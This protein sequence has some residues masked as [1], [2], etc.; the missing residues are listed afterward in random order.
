MAAPGF[1]PGVT[2]VREGAAGVEAFAVAA[3]SA[4]GHA[5]GV[6]WAVVEAPGPAYLVLSE[7][8]ARGWTASV[9]GAPAAVEAADGTL[10]GLPV[11]AGRHAVRFEYR[12]PGLA[13]G[14]ALSAVGLVWVAALVVLARR[15]PGLTRSA[16]SSPGAGP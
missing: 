7:T 13:P 6:A 9:D 16:A 10:L 11:P 15:R 3:V 4:E 1:D 8:W 12:Q 2:A 5:T 14:A